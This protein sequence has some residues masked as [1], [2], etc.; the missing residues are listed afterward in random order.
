[1]QCPALVSA[2]Y[3]NIKTIENYMAVFFSCSILRNIPF[4]ENN[5]PFVDDF[6]SQNVKGV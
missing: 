3:I 1:M 4:N 5:K 6:E 2:T